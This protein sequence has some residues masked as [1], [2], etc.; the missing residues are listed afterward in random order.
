M[1]LSDFV[2]A[3]CRAGSEKA[4]K[5]EVSL[6]PGKLLTPAFMRPQLIT[7]KVQAELPSNFVFDALLGVVCGW[8]LGMAENTDEVMQILKKADLKVCAV[9]VFPR[10][11]PENGLNPEEWAPVDALMDSLK[12]ICPISSE[13]GYVLD[14]ILGGVGEPW[15]IGCHERS[16]AS[17]P[18]A[19][20]L[21]RLTI[22]IEAPSR[23]WLKMEQSL[24]WLGLDSP[25]LLAGKSA[26]ELGSAPGGASWSLLQRGMK[27]IGVDTGEV[28]ACVQNHPNYDHIGL[29]AS[30]L[31]LDYLP[32]SIDLLA[33]DMNLAPDVVL[34]YLE[35]LYQSLK[36]HWL[37]LT[38]KMNDARVEALMP[39]FIQQVQRF[40]SGPVYA[41]Q[42]H[43]N[44]REVTLISRGSTVQPNS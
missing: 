9:H 16:P 19:G 10:L 8:S 44:R 20:A 31:P 7:W 41:K 43:S 17:H 15:F 28:D 29:P 33:C 14:V 22:P 26:L 40:S 13:S 38:F 35:P 30:Q 21:P 12:Q 25:G 34:K 11:I 5:K 36:P 6:Q 2:F 24:A 32:E 39:Y 23:A 4:L 18:S 42:L 1:R 37:V 27:V 3:T